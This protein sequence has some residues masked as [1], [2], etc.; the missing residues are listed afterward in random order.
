MVTI[1]ICVC[2]CV[3]YGLITRASVHGTCCT[4]LYIYIPYILY[5]EE[6]T[7]N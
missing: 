7:M 2:V 1:Y 3:L 5:I 6:F 4:D